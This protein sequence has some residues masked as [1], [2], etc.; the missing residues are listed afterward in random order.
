MSDTGSYDVLVFSLD[1]E[2][3]D[4]NDAKRMGDMDF[5]VFA[6]SFSEAEENAGI[7]WRQLHGHNWRCITRLWHNCVKL[8]VTELLQ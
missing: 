3:H 6:D 5:V 7:K 4:L 8:F 2:S 1:K